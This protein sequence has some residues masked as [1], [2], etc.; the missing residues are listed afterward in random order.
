M[1]N[2]EDGAVM[3]SQRRGCRVGHGCNARRKKTPLINGAGVATREEKEG[4]RDSYAALL[5]RP[6]SGR[7]A[8]RG[9]RKRP[10]R[11]KRDGEEQ[12]AGLRSRERRDGPLALLAA[13]EGKGRAQWAGDDTTCPC[14]REVRDG[15]GQARAGRPLGCMG[16]K[17]SRPSGLNIERE[18]FPF[19]FQNQFK[20]K[21]NQI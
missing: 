8:K 18:N 13:Q 5:G 6:K 11:E 21:P 1:A 2:G 14:G 16:S 7:A 19:L 12:W 20:C 3:D 4:E 15:R 10:R 9:N 17:R